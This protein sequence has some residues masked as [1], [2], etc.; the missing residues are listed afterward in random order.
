MAKWLY[1]YGQDL[2]NAFANSGAV[3]NLCNALVNHGVDIQ[4]ACPESSTNT[5]EIR[6]AYELDP[7]IEILPVL[8]PNKSLA[9]VWMLLTC[10][11]HSDADIYIT[12][13]PALAVLASLLG[14]TTVLELHQRIDTA[15]HWSF[16]RRFLRFIS[17]RR[18][19]FVANSVALSKD[20]DPVVDQKRFKVCHAPSSARDFQPDTASQHRK[21]D[22]GYVGS[23]MPGKG[24]EVVHAI[25]CAHP[26]LSF[27]IYGNPASN[28]EIAEE[29]RSLANVT[30]A[31]FVNQAK[32]S[33]AL[34][35]FRI[36]LAPYSDKGF[37]G[38]NAPFIPIEGLSS[39]KIVEYM[40]AGCVVVSSRIPPVEHVVTDGESAV[41]C[42]ANDM[43]DWI[44]KIGELASDPVRIQTLSDTARRTFLADYSYDVRARTIKSLVEKL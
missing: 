28:P 22:V 8:Q 17:V 1:I 13:M 14:K 43:D 44:S 21:Y 35:S 10:R 16:W 9:A 36:G 40:S 26:A 7:S 3:L 33:D 15:R 4:L 42:D 39:L 29:L 23:F 25:A 12:R 6:A 27:V 2:P 32:I 31:G 37:G 24:I 5:E 30:L 18:L 20:I 11:K 41:L 38:P 19:C 34:Q